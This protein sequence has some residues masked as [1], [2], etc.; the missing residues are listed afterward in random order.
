MQWIDN[1]KI[2]NEDALIVVDVQY[3]FL[4]GGSLEVP[5][6]NEIIKGINKLGERFKQEGKRIIFTQD[7]HTP[8]HAS[9]A[10]SYPDKEPFDPIEGITGVGP[11]VW[12]DH[13]VQG[14]HGAD[15]HE[16]LDQSLAHLI[17][18]KGFNN[19]IDSYSAIKENDKKTE[20][21]LAGYL[22][23]AGIN[24]VVIVG[25]ALDYCV[26]YTAQDSAKK[27]FDVVVVHD[28][29]RG[30]AADSIRK[31]ENKMTELGVKFVKSPHII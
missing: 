31:A 10:S 17:I 13:C 29:T 30:I 20:T 8:H 28:L 27:G 23:N 16:D 22:R 24:R 26:N 18:R 25:L 12:P 15:F 21:G 11:V 19:D 1:L 5:E 14:S 9:F 2:T 7:W 3:D 6:G 4:K